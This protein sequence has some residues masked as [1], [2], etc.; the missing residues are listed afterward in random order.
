MP[1]WTLFIL[2]TLATALLAAAPRKPAPKEVS[3]KDLKFAPATLTIAV[4]DTVR[5]TNNDDVDHTVDAVNGAFSSG[6]LKT[7]Q[8]F[9]FR[10]TKAG[11]YDYGCKL[12]PRTKGRIV[13][14]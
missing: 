10:F 4:G 7:N 8:T 3:I 14:K 13:V 5:W 9:E 2:L 12:R 6:K 11:T 1:R